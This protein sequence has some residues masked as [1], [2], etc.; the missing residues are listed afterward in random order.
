MVPLRYLSTILSRISPITPDL[1]GEVAAEVSSNFF[2]PGPGV[3]TVEKAPDLSAEGF[4]KY[5]VVS[6]S[7][8][9]SNHHPNLL[10]AQRFIFCLIDRLE[11]LRVF[12]V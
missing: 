7:L 6:A 5:S 9:V 10:L 11:P 12:A 1:I 2:R 8:D 3:P 4:Y